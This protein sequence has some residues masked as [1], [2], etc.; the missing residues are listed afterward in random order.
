[1]SASCENVKGLTPP[2]VSIADA[3]VAEGNAG[4]TVLAFSVS[5]SKASK[6]PASVDFATANGTATAPAD[7]ASSSGK[8][9]FAP[10]ETSKTVNVSVVGD[11]AFEPNET[12]SVALSGPVNAKLADGSASGTITNDDPAYRAGSYAG[13][14]AQGKAINFDVSA[15]AKQVVNVT[16]GFD[17][18]CSEAPGFTISDTLRILV[19]LTIGPDGAISLS[20]SESD[21]ESK[22]TFEFNGKLTA[23][24]SASGT[25]TL[26]I[27]LYG[28]PGIGTLHCQTGATPVA[29]NAS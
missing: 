5:L 16:F 10:G 23:P 8:V 26:A 9:M 7:F 24:S 21:S 19:P 6:R 2:T 18:N 3:T 1:M 20:D 4:S 12:L 28:I 22:L 14:T 17:L 27:E 13:T 15:D 11:S 25:F 29:W